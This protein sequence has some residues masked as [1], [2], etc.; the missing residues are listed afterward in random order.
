[1]ITG[2]IPHRRYFKILTTLCAVV[3]IALAIDPSYRED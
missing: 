2:V 1:L 3:W